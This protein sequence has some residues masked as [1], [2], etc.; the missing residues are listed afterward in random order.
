MT[1]A[2]TRRIFCMEKRSSMNENGGKSQL[3]GST[4]WGALIRN[5]GKCD[6]VN[7]SCEW[8][9]AVCPRSCEA[10][11]SNQAEQI[12]RIS[13]RNVCAKVSV[14]ATGNSSGNFVQP[15]GGCREHKKPM[16][17]CY[18]YLCEVA[19]PEK[20][21]QYPASCKGYDHVFRSAVTP[22]KKNIEREKSL[23]NGHVE[24]LT[25]ESAAEKRQHQ[26]SGMVR[27]L[28]LHM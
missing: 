13:R 15:V 9:I 25:C 4:T 23:P 12:S 1:M 5:G 20:T 21:A 6:A 2:S 11:R 7:G 26:P 16:V 28:L 19:S 27:L 17:S 8:V 10:A 14:V 22:G 24:A 18:G 3:K